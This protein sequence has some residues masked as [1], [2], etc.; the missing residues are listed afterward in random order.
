M[1]IVDENG[2]IIGAQFGTQGVEANDDEEMP[3]EQLLPLPGQRVVEMDV[4]D[5]IEHLP[6]S[7]LTRFFSAVEVSWPATIKMPRIEVV[8]RTRD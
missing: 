7:D 8:R 5:E 2:R 4:P 6:A 3:S 1:A